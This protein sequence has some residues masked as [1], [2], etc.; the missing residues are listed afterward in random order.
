MPSQTPSDNSNILVCQILTIATTFSV[1]ML[2]IPTWDLL[3][4]TKYEIY[5]TQQ[6]FTSHHIS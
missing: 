3:K 5:L 6:V 2:M 1:K 4:L